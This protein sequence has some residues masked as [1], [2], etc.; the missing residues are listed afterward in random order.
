MAKIFMAEDDP[1][2]GRM[3]ERAFRAS[4]YELEIALDGEE[5]ISKLEKMESAPTIMLLD[6]MMPKINGFDVLR[7]VKQNEKLKS[8]P[9]VMLTNLAGQ[10]DAEK[11]LS[12]G[13]VLYLVKSQYDPKEILNKVKE[14]IDGATHGDAVP[15]VKVEVKDTK[16]E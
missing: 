12:L 10:A 3:Y 2:M 5:A 6:V 4:G 15:E 1:L 11:A 14:I 9:V 16:K 13:A 8:V 7:K